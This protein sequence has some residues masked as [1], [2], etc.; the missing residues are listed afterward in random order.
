MSHSSKLRI[1]NESILKK[2]IVLADEMLT[3]SREKNTKNSTGY[4]SRAV[5]IHLATGMLRVFPL[6]PG[7]NRKIS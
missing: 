6:R 4:E 1:L 7:R 5:G 2:K 3:T